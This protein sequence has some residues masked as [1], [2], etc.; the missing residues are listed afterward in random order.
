MGSLQE[1]IEDA[2]IGYE[3]YSYDLDK[4]EEMKLA[5]FDVLIVNGDRHSGNYLVKNGRIFAIDHGLSFER[6]YL[7]SYRRGYYHF[8]IGYGPVLD[9]IADKLRRFTR[10]EEQKSLLRDLISELL[11]EVIADLFIKRVEAF[12]DSIERDGSF[13]EQKFRDRLAGQIL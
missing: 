6:T 13:D 5:I 8:D 1:F 9:E 11:G 7:G 4:D 12:T 10:S 3:I 2:K